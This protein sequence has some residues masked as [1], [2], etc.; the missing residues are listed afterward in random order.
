MRTNRR[1]PGVRKDALATL[2]A[3]VLAFL[4]LA[5][6]AH[7]QGPDFPAGLTPEQIFEGGTNT[8]VNWIELSAGGLLT[9]GDNAQAQQRQHMSNGAFGGVED[10]HF[11]ENLDKKTLFT[12]D[13]HGLFDL[14]DYKLSLALTRE[15][16]GYVRFN[17]ENFRTWYDGAGGYF[18][19]DNV[20]YRLPNDDLHIDRGEISFEAGLTLKDAPQVV[21]KYTHR[22]QDGDRSSTDWGPAQTSVGTRSLV[23][24]FYDINEKADIFQ[25]DV[26][27]HIK[28]T[29]FG[30]GVR[31]ETGNLDDAFNVMFRPGEPVQQ[32]LT[33]KQGTSYDMFSVHAFT[34][35]WFQKSL[36]LSTGFLYENLDNTFSGSRI[37]GDDFDVAYMPNTL[38]GLGYFDLHGGSHQ[39]EYVLNVNLMTIPLNQFTIVPAIRVQKDDWNANSSGTGTL[40]DLTPEAFTAS[41]ERDVLEVRERIDMRYSAVTNWVFYAGPEWTEGQGD[42]K[43]NGGLTQVG[44]IG[45]PPVQED[46]DDSHF[47]QKYFAGATWYPTRRVT[48]DVGGYFK[49][50]N[51]DYNFDVD[52]TSN[53]STSPN[54]YPAYLTMQSFNTYDANGRLTLRPLQNL[55]L[56]SRYEYQYSQTHTTPDP[57]SGLSGVDSSQI[58]SQIIGQN[59]CWTPWS[60]LNLQVGFNYVLS[61]TKT[62]TSEYT[63]A[64]LNSLNNYWTL[65]FN[66]GVVLDDKTDLNLGY[67]YYAADDFQNNSLAGLPLGAGGRENGVTA[68]LSRRLTPNLR[69]NLRYGYDNYDDFASGG[70]NSYR[71]QLIYS[72]LQYRF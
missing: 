29:T 19:L 1:G 21:F 67:Y 36:F 15:E 4:F 69:L 20:Q 54:R 48:L 3:C 62:P 72:S 37:Y 6:R 55:T 43:Q 53:A 7:A 27:H 5:A 65:N 59:I 25:L 10:L 49:Q 68:T 9:S 16:V 24:G 64:V 57:I 23:P 42:L 58:T 52:S 34:E 46:T 51:Y 8:Y 35:T 30:A 31:Y 60:R 45:L 39:N 38:S 2:S 28:A 50:N 11:Q 22:Y 33:D 44:G 12:L 47:Y 56:V 32:A 63:Q 40:A 71:A 18:P 70:N 66:A 26:T 17:Y 13:G 61:E 41:S 14:H